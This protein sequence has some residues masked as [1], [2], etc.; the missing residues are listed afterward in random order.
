MTKSKN[1]SQASSIQ[2]LN[3]RVDRIMKMIPK[4]AFRNAGSAAGMAVGG[5]AGAVVG[6]AIGTGLSAITGYGDYE[7]SMNSLNKVSTSVDTVPTFVRNDHSVRVTHR[8]YVRDLNVPTNPG[9]FNNDA[10]P[11]NPSNVNL[12]PWLAN[13]S[14]Q[15]QQYRIHGMIVEYKTMSSDYA[16]SGPLGTVC[17]ATNYNVLDNKYATKIALENSEFAVSCKPSMSL[18]HA[19]ECDPKV[20]GRDILYVR[21]LASESGAPADAR[22]YDAGLLQ[23]ATAGL[24]G[25]AG[26]TLGEVWISYDI[27]F[28]K[29]VLASYV[30]PDPEPTVPGFA[31]VSQRD[32]TVSAANG[33]IARIQYEAEPKAF[34]FNANP[35]LYDATAVAPTLVGDTALDGTACALSTEGTVTF[36]RNGRYVVTW[37]LTVDT[38][39]SSYYLAALTSLLSQPNAALS[40]GASG[41]IST[42]YTVASVGN[43]LQYP[44]TNLV[45]GVATAEVTIRGMGDGQTATLACPR[46]TAAGISLSVNNSCR[47]QITW[48]QLEEANVR[49]VE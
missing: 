40:G 2:S 35:Y 25:V 3:S 27:E 23:I 28:Y 8:E 45:G 1:T 32:G 30:N 24:P 29:P 16:A 48:Q 9:A 15:Y 4:G 42:L 49:L 44:F 18:I 17:I 19:I 21:D 26:S 22:L 14:R 34:G 47:T 11:I 20:T 38:T 12:F 10:Q 5:P 33:A 46:F 36:Y 41:T 6:R 39:D 37:T 43:R 7:V 13:M 31:L